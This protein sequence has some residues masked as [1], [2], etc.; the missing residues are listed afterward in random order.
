MTE[1]FKN[2]LIELTGEATLLVSPSSL[3]S[4]DLRDLQESSDDDTI[5][6]VKLSDY[7]DA[8]S[9]HILCSAMLRS[10]RDENETLHAALHA[11]ASSDAD[12]IARAVSTLPVAEVELRVRRVLKMVR[13]FRITSSKRRADFRPIQSALLNDV[14]SEL[15]KICPVDDFEDYLQDLFNE[16]E[17]GNSG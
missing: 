10:I 7:A 4:N 13:Y 6:M 16:L 2:H 5:I 15:E 3:S 11:K 12:S 14:V 9:K 8:R 17:D 1:E